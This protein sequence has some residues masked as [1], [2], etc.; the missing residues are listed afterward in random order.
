MH[1]THAPDAHTIPW[2]QPMPSGA[3]PDSLQTASPVEQSVVP[4]RQGLL[5]TV[6]C[7]P[8]EQGPQAPS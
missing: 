5:A 4:V 8:A 1:A 3:L 2:P 7:V 6:H